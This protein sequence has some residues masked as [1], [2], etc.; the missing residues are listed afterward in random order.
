MYEKP[1]WAK[2]VKT[3]VPKVGANDLS[4][5]E[6]EQTFKCA[7]CG[8]CMMACP[9]FGETGR[10]AMC[11]RGRV[12]LLRALIEGDLELTG[13]LRDKIYA[14]LG[15]N[16]CNQ[17]CPSGVNLEELMQEARAVLRA[18]GV[19]LPSLQEALR[20]NLAGDGNPFGEKRGE[21]GAWLP[22]DRRAPRASETCVHAGCAISYANTRTGRMVLRILEKAGADFTLMGSEEEC[23]GDP[24]VRLGETRLA[25]E[26]QERN[27]A[28]FRRYG[29]KRIVTPCAGCIKSFRR[30]YPEFESLHI[31]EW[32]AQLIRDG[33]LKPSRP[34]VKKVIYFDGCDIGRHLSIYEPPREI[35]RAI[36]GLTLLEFPKNREFAQ[37]CGGPMMSN[38]PL[39]AK[40][41][42]AK[43]VREALAAGA[44]IIAPACPTCFIALRDGAKHINQRMD[45]QDVV[46]LLFKSLT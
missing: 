43:R 33:K 39:M 14:C 44:E 12:Q 28:R 13:N 25:R 5:K 35:L 40:N 38:D 36:P 11:A 17:H 7:R 15:C 30:Y 6:V 10:E 27:K 1:R 41:I 26:L 22:E 20:G 16:A 3:A 46:S 37:C 42:A 4:A 9:L 8:L 34:V 2:R 18:K 32:I 29:V 24:L 45:V 21:R 31:V 23:C 19:E